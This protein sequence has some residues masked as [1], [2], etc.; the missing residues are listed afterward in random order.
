MLR[1]I[2]D[3]TS[4]ARAL[5][6][7]VVVAAAA[8]SGACASAPPPPS[9]SPGDPSNPSAAES[10]GVPVMPSMAAAAPASGPTTDAPTIYA[11]PMHPEVTSTQPSQKCA[12][13]GMT[14]VPR[15]ATP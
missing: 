14:L 2:R 4:G 12:K 13:C 10:S 7:T 11:C 6:F 1:I 15:K 3:L 8:L 5:R 9:Q